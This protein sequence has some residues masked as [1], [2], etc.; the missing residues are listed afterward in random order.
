MKA[1]ILTKAGRSTGCSSPTT[2]RLVPD[3]GRLFAG[4]T[5]RSTMPAGPRQRFPRPSSRG[6]HHHPST[7]ASR[8]SRGVRVWPRADDYRAAIAVG[9]GAID[10][11]RT[12]R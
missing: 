12:C 7:G 10:R 3:R 9:P 2:G 11:D 8:S 1:K 5:T 4:T 6:R